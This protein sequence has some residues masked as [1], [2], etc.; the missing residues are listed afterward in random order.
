V[1]AGEFGFEFPRRDRYLLEMARRL[2]KCCGLAGPL[3]GGRRGL[4]QGA[5][6]SCIPAGKARPSCAY[7][8]IDNLHRSTIAC[9]TPDGDHYKQQV[10]LKA[11][12]MVAL[13]LP[14]SSASS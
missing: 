7:F 14:V 9:G 2:R 4:C 6:L 11:S 10:F 1:R 8:L 3:V 13:G 12:F 5:D